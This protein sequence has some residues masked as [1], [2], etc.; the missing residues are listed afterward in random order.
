MARSRGP[1]HGLDRFERNTEE[2]SGYDFDDPVFH[3]HDEVIINAPVI[4]A[5][6]WNLDTRG[7]LG[8]GLDYN[9]VLRPPFHMYHSLVKQDAIVNTVGLT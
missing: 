1:I 7:D 4:E 8:S 6:Q 2:E 9:L 5:E 3:G